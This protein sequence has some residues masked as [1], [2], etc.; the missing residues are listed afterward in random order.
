M[1]LIW[2]EFVEKGNER[3]FSLLYDKYA[4]SLFS[5]GMCLG[6]TEEQC[7]DALQ[8]VFIKL[9]ISKK[10]LTH[11]TNFSAYLFRAYKHKLVDMYR[12]SSKTEK[13]DLKS[14]AF[15]VSATVLEHIVEQEEAVRL[16]TTLNT[17]LAQLTK[18]QRRVVYMKYMH[19]MNYAEIGEVMQLHPDSCKKMVYRA[20]EKLREIV[21]KR[22]N[23]N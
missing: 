5:Y 6:F 9:F 3:L 8:D 22:E 14:H 2:K 17:L 15:P 18:K 21:K 16:E 13:L 4:D 12:E 19:G 23:H 10:R 7:R 20:I 11:I 1:Q